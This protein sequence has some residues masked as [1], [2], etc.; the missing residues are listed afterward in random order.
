MAGLTFQLPDLLVVSWPAGTPFFFLILKRTTLRPPT[1]LLLDEVTLPL[2]APFLKP[3]VI[4]ELKLPP[5]GVVDEVADAEPDGDFDAEAEL[6]LPPGR[7]LGAPGADV[8]RQVSL[9]E[10]GLEDVS[11]SA[12][13]DSTIAT[14][15]AQ[16]PK[17][18][19]S[20][21]RA[22]PFCRIE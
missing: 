18:T 16:T 2:K 22:L 13:D 3:I 1:H 20:A 11:P 4:F 17:E 8:G 7:Q 6:E 12:V 19:M 10:P 9:R 21:I 14:E 15:S 5:E